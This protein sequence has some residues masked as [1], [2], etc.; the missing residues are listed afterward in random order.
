MGRN[1]GAAHKK[2]HAPRHRA[3]RGE[4][5][6][7]VVNCSE[8]IESN[9]NQ[10]L[11][12]DSQKSN[13]QSKAESACKT[14]AE[15]KADYFPRTLEFYPFAYALYN[16]YLDKH[17]WY[18]LSPSANLRRCKGCNRAMFCDQNCQTLGWKDHKAECRA[19][20]G[21]PTVPDIEVRLLGRI[22]TRFK[23]IKN[24]NDKKDATFYL[25]RSSRR[26]IMDI[27]AHTDQIRN[28]E[29]AMKKF[30]DVYSRLVT[31]YG[32]KALLTK[33]EAFELHCRDYINR[34]AISDDGYL[35]EIGKGLY[36]DLCAYDHSC[37]P[38]TIY[39]C[40]GFVATLR[41]LDLTVNLMDRTTTFYSY[42]DLLSTTQERRKLLRDTW[43]F[44]CQ[45]VRCVD[46]DDHVL[47][48]M[49][50]PSCREKPERLCIFGES[51]YKNPV[52]QILTCPKCHI[53]VPKERVLEAVDAMRF[54]D[55]IVAKNE[56]Q[57]MAKEQAFR[58]LK[59]IKDR[60]SKILPSVNVYMCKIIQL[61][62]PLIDPTD[63][64]TLLSLHLESEECVRFCFPPNHPAV[65]VHL[66]SIGLFYLR[67]GHPHRAEL[68]LEMACDILKFTLG[69]THPLTVDKLSILEEAHR[70]VQE[71]RRI[72][73]DSSISFQIPATPLLTAVGSAETR[74]VESVIGDAS[75]KETQHEEPS[76]QHADN[77]TG[78][79]SNKENNHKDEVT[80]PSN[81][82]GS[83]RGT[84]EK[85]QDL[86]H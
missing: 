30:N 56:I 47:S 41:A 3:K 46:N 35:E 31:F 44:D 53:E 61:L 17:C 13:E 69:H 23:A 85:E 7:P 67:I 29:F 75:L 66:S 84:V 76:K 28:D 4:S 32:T 9:E 12:E 22:I 40:K 81:A 48:S 14:T 21:S 19:L 79:E 50:C 18:C 60:F 37:R 49:F 59:G 2:T 83:S 33:E 57:Q 20:K 51:P 80:T 77:V 55:R 5:S 74:G 34:H 16:N 10:G 36:L 42:I 82:N 15:E 68:Y 39:T 6:A 26:S 72:M 73:L 58:F 24:G 8:P 64:K 1:N 70:E 52:T 27:W 62:I 54:I 11:R 63:S 65:A 86:L 38:N 71:A 43:Y 45:C 78:R 25:Q